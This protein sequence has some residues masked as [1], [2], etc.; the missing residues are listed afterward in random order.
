M[1]LVNAAL[2][3]PLASLQHQGCWKQVAVRAQKQLGYSSMH[4][5]QAQI[6]VDV[7]HML[8]SGMSILDNSLLCLSYTCFR[9]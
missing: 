5:L 3:Q 7:E 2:W 1:V 9:P 4:K 8:D 6:Y